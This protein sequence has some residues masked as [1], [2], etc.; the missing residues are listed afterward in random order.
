MV[1]PIDLT[2]A[3]GRGDQEISGLSKEALEVP[4]FTSV[5]IRHLLNNLGALPDRHYL[6][7]GVHKGGTFV[8]TNF[9]NK[10]L[11]S[12]AVDNWSN[13]A[14]DGQS[15][16]EFYTNCDTLLGPK[17]YTCYNQDSFTLVKKQFKKPVN[18]YLY[19]GDHSY[20]AQY[21]ALSHLYP[22]LAD[23]FVFLVDDYSDSFYGAPHVKNGTQDAIR[24]LKLNVLF[25]QEMV[26]NGERAD[27]WWNG[28][29]IFLLKK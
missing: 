21:K 11:S 7:I 26:G 17:A 15:E 28:L 13:C 29:G 16:K 4:S 1:L 3:L 10:L 2:A 9:G 19:D 14:Q 8:S 6:E 20:D 5:K 25:E 24:D 12:I 23:E 18:L 22:M 27:G